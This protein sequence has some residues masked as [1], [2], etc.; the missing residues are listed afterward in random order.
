MSIGVYLITNK[1]NGDTYI[2]QS[3]NIERRWMEHKAPST[4]QKDTP[5]SN[6]MRQY[7][8]SSFE[9][10]VLEI[11]HEK[12]LDTLEKY[13]IKK[14]KP[15]Y[16]RNEGGKGNCGHTLSDEVRQRLREKG[17]EQWKRKSPE[18]KA[19]IISEQLIGV[20][21]GHIVSEATRQ[22]LR[23]A[24]L[25]KKQSATTIAKRSEKLKVRLKGNTNRK[26]AVIAVNL[27]TLEVEI[28]PML[29]NA[30]RHI[31]TNP[32][33]LSHTLK[34]ERPIIKG[35]YITYLRSVETNCDE[36]SSVGLEMSTSSK[37]VA[38]HRGEEIVHAHEMANR[39]ISDK[40]FIQLAIRSGQ[41]KTLNVTD[42]REG[43]VKNCNLLTGEIEF[44]MLPKR[45]DLPIVG[46][47]SFFR[48][49][50]GFEKTLYITKGEMEQHAN[51]YSQTYASKNEYTRKAS[52]WT[53]DFDAMARKTA[54]K[55][56]L[57]KYAPLSI[58][59]QTAVTADQA[60]I[61]ARGV[62]YEDNAPQMADAEEVE[63]TEL[64]VDEE[65]GEIIE[66]EPKPQKTAKEKAE[67]AIAQATA[68]A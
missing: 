20:S 49:T 41:F 31:S 1:I 47:A 60:V 14:L 2:G 64:L 28:F 42:V 29:L 26:R 51:T 11:C 18:E 17:R 35:W 56:L 39:G 53:T 52:K 32:T 30:A 62:R 54:I 8:I 66:E 40:G 36:C 67:E 37:C 19:R 61:D 6:A 4:I 58:D 25:G 22:K 7:G 10:A 13:Y 45:E 24:N 63:A 50:N 68:Q 5:L 34:K 59:M 23:E 27:S 65:T 43:E 44:N 16:N 46:Y 33:H 12:E 38:P 9:L 15:T 57:S 21:K 55:L 48:L 3:K